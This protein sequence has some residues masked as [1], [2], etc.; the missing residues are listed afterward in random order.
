M[1]VKEFLGN[2][3]GV[4][5]T[6]GRPELL[7]TFLNI[8][9]TLERFH[10]EQANEPFERTFVAK[11]QEP[12]GEET[13]SLPRLSIGLR[14]DESE[15][16]DYEIE[17]VLGQGGMGRVCKA[18]QTS[19]GREI[20]LKEV[21]SSTEQ[22]TSA[23]RLVH[24]ARI[25]GQLE[26]PNIIPVHDL[27]Q[28][29]TQQPVLIMKRVQGVT[30]KEVLQD[31]AHPFWDDIEESRLSWNLK[32]LIQICN[33]VEFAHTKNI[34]H[35]DI[36]PENVMLGNFGE[37]YLL[38][39][40]LGFEWSKPVAN[41]V[42][43]AAGSPAYMAPEML[44]DLVHVDHRTDIYLLGATLFEILEGRG[45][46]Q[47]ATLSEILKNIV[48]GVPCSF[49][50]DPHLMLRDICVKSMAFEKNKR[51]DSVK[52]FRRALE[53]FLRSLSS[54]ELLA[55]T[56]SRQLEFTAVA[57]RVI[58]SS[59][60]PDERDL[61]MLSKL[62]FE[63]RFGFE[64]SIKQWSE[65]EIAKGEL[66]ALIREMV[67]IQI[68]R[69]EL[70][71]AQT[72]MAQLTHEDETLRKRLDERLLE[73]QDR[74][75]RTSYLEN[76]AFENDASVG[77]PERIRFVKLTALVAVIL[78][79]VIGY[80]VLKYEVALTSQHMMFYAF[81][82]TIPAFGCGY[83]FRKTLFG[84][85][86]SSSMTSS[87]LGFLLLVILIRVFHAVTD[88]PT[89]TVAIREMMMGTGFFLIFGVLFDKLAVFG[90]L[91]GLICSAWLH[92]YPSDFVLVFSGYLVAILILS[93]LVVGREVGR[94]GE[95]SRG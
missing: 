90:S 84:N 7:Q 17:E 34:V 75:A 87:V 78:H 67:K 83:L 12:Q 3:L 63:C 28:T 42:P 65:N 60:K 41:H 31:D 61:E 20:A 8:S 55:E 94:G 81:G 52:A 53:E 1:Q 2:A 89:A 72:L 73:E 77:L 59:S 79:V 95:P 5:T 58:G 66:N 18:T 43:Q 26:H 33:A 30:W 69:N 40:G 36:K 80:Q 68:E 44:H 11:P 86:Q 62:F 6:Y 74:Q 37:A 24:E 21:L 56:R 76:I 88:A 93:Y 48:D 57:S 54:L 45:P 19:L 49:E 39:W 32:I 82:I 9:E 85:R 15:P 14:T 92:L 16:L 4:E 13:T 46:H 51:F 22:V 64:L 70:N 50:N 23:V 27:G 38:D 91:L 29:K 25:A 71:Q 10:T 35:R 47:G